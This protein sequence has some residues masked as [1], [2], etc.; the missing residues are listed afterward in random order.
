LGFFTA[1]IAFVFGTIT[2]TVK[3]NLQASLILISAFGL[4]MIVFA[5]C[6]SILFVKSEKKWFEDKRFWVLTLIV[7]LIFLIVRLGNSL[8]N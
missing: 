8:V 5:L 4:I 1:I 2:I 3:L 6:L 7:F